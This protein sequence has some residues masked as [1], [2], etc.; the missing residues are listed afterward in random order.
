[1]ARHITF[2][3]TAG[4][5]AHQA[6]AFRSTADHT[7]V[8]DCEF[9]GHQDT[10]YAHALRQYYHSCTIAGTVD[11]TFGNSAAVFRR[12]LFLVRPRQLRPDKGESNAVTAHGRT[13]PAQTTGFA[14]LD[15]AVNGTDEYVR[16]FRQKPSAHR[17]FLG[18]P[19]KEYS[20]TVFVRCSLEALVR[21]EG[22]L[23]WKGDFAL[24]TLYYGEYQSTGDGAAESSARVGW[25]S[26]I[27][28][29]KVGVYE[30]ER[31][32]QGEEW[33]PEL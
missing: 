19:W 25:S 3:N 5:D 14:V 16:L 12:C 29:D 24:Q 6:V 32:I 21:P 11:F 18:R 28:A 8:A 15:S 17:N 30:P 23:P 13:D 10:L 9:L 22:W 4:P 31:F 7:V 1:M 20:R 26:Q 33:I 2:E 27:P